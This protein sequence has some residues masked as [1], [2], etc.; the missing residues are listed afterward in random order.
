MKFSIIVTTYKNSEGLTIVAKSLLAQVYKDWELI[1][2]N[3]SPSDN[4]Y[5]T[6]ASS[7]NDPRIRY[8]V[9]ETH[10]GEHL[11]YNSGLEKISA[12]SKW[13]L[14][15][16]DTHYFSPD[17]LLY[18]S[19]LIATNSEQKWFTTNYA[20]KDGTPYTKSSK[21]EA[22]YSYI[23]DYLILK[24]IKGPMTHCAEAKLINE[25]K[26]RFSNFTKYNEDWFFYYQ[27][28]LHTKFFYSD[29][30]STIE[31]SIPYQ[32][33]KE[34]LTYAYENIVRLCYEASSKKL[35]HPSFVI[36]LLAR[37]ISRE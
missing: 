14:F 33:K 27:V 9:N 31:N 30:N 23:I 16:K 17:T 2:I 29:H 11:S 19:R 6:F 28:S 34:T 12:D 35:L 26:I 3:D 5:H 36:A 1:I 4:R 24:K 8:Y 32:K 22:V 25:N 7:L 10:R 21:D 13:I 37:C 20:H 18:F 15:L